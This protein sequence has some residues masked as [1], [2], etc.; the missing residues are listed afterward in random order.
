MAAYEYFT[1]DR[2]VLQR[3]SSGARFWGV[4]LDKAM[5]TYFEAPPGV[6][7]ET[8]RHESEQITLVLEGELRFEI[9]GRTVVVGPGEVIAIAPNVPHAVFT[10]DQA[11]RAVDA[12]SPVM[13]LYRS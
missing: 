6:R 8:H 10:Q 2:L 1:R 11:A 13:E 12:W 4:A 3:D 9:E 5:L 7:F